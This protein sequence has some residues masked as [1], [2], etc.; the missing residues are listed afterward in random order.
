[1]IAACPTP[2]AILDATPRR[3]SGESTPNVTN[4]L[5]RFESAV[6]RLFEGGVGKVFRSSVQPAEIGRKLERAMVSS[7][8]VSMDATIAPND[9]RVT[10]CPDDLDAF[11]DFLPALARHLESCLADIATE[12]RFTLLDRLHVDLL[13]D[14]AL[15]RRAITVETAFTES[16]EP[17]SP[18]VHP[19]RTVPR[20]ARLRVLN[21]PQVGQELPLRAPLA[22]IGRAAD[23]DVVLIADDVSRYHARIDIAGGEYRLTDLGSTNGTSVNRRPVSYTLIF[24]GD[25]VQCGSVQLRLVAAETR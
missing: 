4:P 5:D 10:M 16:T 25:E 24:P 12:R 1:M 8:H 23:N 19:V 20:I 22:T 2:R 7:T 13:P 3:R 11:A 14:P 21:G 18:P 6:E 15:P 9:Y 17:E